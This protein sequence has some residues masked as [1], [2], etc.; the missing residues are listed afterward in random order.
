MPTR[1]SFLKGVQWGFVF[2]SGFVY[3]RVY[4]LKNNAKKPISSV[5][6]AKYLNS[7]SK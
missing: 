3:I 1:L 4:E 5:V 6:R 7:V 2:I